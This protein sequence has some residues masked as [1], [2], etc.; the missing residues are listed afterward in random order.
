[1]MFL[2]EVIQKYKDIVIQIATPYSTGTGFY[3]AQYKIIITNEHVVREN[4]EVVIEG[5]HLEK[6]LA[7]VLYL[8]QKYDLAFI[9]CKDGQK[10]AGVS[11][12]S[13]KSLL[14]L[15]QVVVAIGH[16]YGL[17]FAATQG[18][19]SNII[20][21]ENGINYFQ[22]DASLN[23]GN[24][25]GPLINEKGELIG[26]NTF[27]VRDGNNIGF[28]LPS[29]YLVKTID[30]FLAGNYLQG[31]RCHNCV[32]IVFENEMEG[33]YCIHC[34]SRLTM[35][36]S[37]DVYEAIGVSKTIEEML[38]ALGY[39]VELSRRGP[40]NWEISKGSAIITI[41][42]HEKSGLIIADAF[43]CL[44]PKE[45]IKSLYEYL[46]KE[47]YQNDSLTFSVKNQD[48]ILSILI[49]DQYLNATTATKLLQELFDAADKYDDILVQNF[50]ARWKDDGDSLPGWK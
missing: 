9:E 41:S 25:G 23:P 34:G 27:V 46:L 11:V 19:L 26:V 2:H 38:E 33:K 22:H 5:E 35:I 20:Y 36:S 21:E 32:N 1:M 45:N 29:E 8:D 30:E 18:I 47:N 37:L 24:S 15:G 4:K 16:P 44:L 17:P 43:L 31:V 12:I 42:Y 7:R 28:S 50:N 6:Q 49:Y 10:M 13:D 40:N 14:T 39:A 3:L 48:V